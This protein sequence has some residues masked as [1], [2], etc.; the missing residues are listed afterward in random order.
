MHKIV[1]NRNDLASKL[2]GLEAQRAREKA[3]KQLNSR[4]FIISDSVIVEILMGQTLEILIL[5]IFLYIHGLKMVHCGLNKAV[6][7]ERF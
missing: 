7:R 5:Q 2:K 6:T 4:V 1:H 3:A